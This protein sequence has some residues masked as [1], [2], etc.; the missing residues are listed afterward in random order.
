MPISKRDREFRLPQISCLD[1]KQLEM[2]RVLTSFFA[3]LAHNGFPSRL[4]RN[5][6]LTTDALVVSLDSD[7]SADAGTGI[8]G[9]VILNSPVTRVDSD[10]APLD[11]PFLD[12]NSHLPPVCASRDSGNATGSFTVTRRRGLRATPDGY[13][14]AFGG[15]EDA[16]RSHEIASRRRS[17]PAPESDDAPDMTL[18]QVSIANATIAMACSR[19][20]IGRPFVVR[21]VLIRDLY[22]NKTIRLVSTNS[23]ALNFAKY[24]PAETTRPLSSVPFQTTDLFPAWITSLAIRFRTNFPDTS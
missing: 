19:C 18:A 1:F 23:P 9:D 7:I 13:L 24:T 2:D 8:N 3:R 22:F 11:T 5:R 15:L 6:E 21:A 17:L 20:F 16:G 12:A 10:L 4:T 14:I